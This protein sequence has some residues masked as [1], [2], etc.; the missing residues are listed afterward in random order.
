MLK[1]RDKGVVVLRG[2]VEPMLSLSNSYSDEKIS[3][4]IASLLLALPTLF[5]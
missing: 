3:V 5:Y 1:D 4:S 2:R